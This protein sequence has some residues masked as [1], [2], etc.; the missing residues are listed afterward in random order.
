MSKNIYE[1]KTKII[2]TDSI[3]CPSKRGKMSDPIELEKTFN[4]EKQLVEI[5][6]DDFL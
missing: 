2:G 6:L 3:V 5:F 4:R 1:I